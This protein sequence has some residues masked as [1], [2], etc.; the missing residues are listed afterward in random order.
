ML[1]P[2]FEV[3]LHAMCRNECQIYPYNR[4]VPAK[5]PLREP[6]LL[7]QIPD[8]DR[9]NDK[10]MPIGVKNAGCSDTLAAVPTVVRLTTKLK[11]ICDSYD[12]VRSEAKHS[13]RFLSRKLVD[14]NVGDM[15]VPTS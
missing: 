1:V 4:R 13:E 7:F 15:Y 11:D 12:L 8:Q 14:M 3:Y 9:T 2:G 10:W 6:G 5:I